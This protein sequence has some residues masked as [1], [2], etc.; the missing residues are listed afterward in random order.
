MQDKQIIAGIDEAGYGPLLGPYVL[1]V[2]F[3][4]YRG[5]DD[6]A[7]VSPEFWDALADGVSRTRSKDRVAVGDSKQLYQRKK[8][9]STLETGVLSF[10]AAQ[11]SAPAC[12]RGLLETLGQAPEGLDDYPWYAGKDFSLPVDTFSPVIAHL[13][14]KLSAVQA[15]SPFQ[16][17]G[18]R[19]RILWAGAFN[20]MVKQYDN[21][22]RIGLACIAEIL[23]RIWHN[24]KTA[25]SCVYIDRQGG[26][27]RYAKFLWQAL[28]PG[29]IIGL[30]ESQEK[31]MYRLE[32]QS[33]GRGAMTVCFMRKGDR[34]ALPVA[35]ASMMA[36]YVRELHMRLFNEYFAAQVGETLKPTAGYVQDGRRFLKDIESCLADRG[37]TLPPELLIRQR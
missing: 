5:K 12:F 17:L 23:K 13:A 11:A 28:N 27:I 6:V 4:E 24:E 7:S 9:L 20:R 8:G 1:G 15:A 21:K 16:F 37:R 25:S 35:L 14:E 32:H 18:F 22:A 31:S 2:S 34:K 10:L 26:R 36:K 3:F 29:R 33:G 30:G 19:S